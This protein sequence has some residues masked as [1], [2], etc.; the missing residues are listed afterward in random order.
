MLA[1]EGMPVEIGRHGHRW[2]TQR[3]TLDDVVRSWDDQVGHLQPGTR[4]TGR[5]AVNM[6]RARDLLWSHRLTPTQTRVW[7]LYC[8]G[9]SEATIGKT[10]RRSREFLLD[11][12]LGMLKTLCGIR[13]RPFT[14]RGRV[15]A[16]KKRRK[17]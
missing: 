1:A 13:T 4:R 12:V 6:D 16:R 9:D 7:A 8:D 10:V 2:W 5:T 15:N 3:P 17:P 11:H 14:Q